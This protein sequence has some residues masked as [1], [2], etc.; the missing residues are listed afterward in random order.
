[1]LQLIKSLNFGRSLNQNPHLH[2]LATSGFWLENIQSHEQLKPC[3][4]EII[5][6]L[7]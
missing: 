6:I 7:N 5:K 3:K 4:A 1:M 2:T